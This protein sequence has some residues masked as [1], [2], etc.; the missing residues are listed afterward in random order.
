MISLPDGNTTIIIQGKK[1]FEVEE[2]LKNDPY[3]TAKVKVLEDKFPARPNKE[4]KALMDSLR[5]SA[6]KILK[7]NPEI[8]REAQV[9][10]DNIDSNVFLIQFLA[11]NVNAEIKDKQTLLEQNDLLECASSLLGLMN[12]DI[13]FLEIKRDIHSK[14]HTDLDKEQRN[15][16]LRQQIKVL[17]EELGMESTDQEV[18]NLRLRGEAKPWSETIAKHFNK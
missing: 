18:D 2:Y 8:P 13:Q 4:V 9:A 11:S 14:V 15:Y 12:K 10:I 1:R 3:I 6:L 7:L 17:Q 5:Q 16:Y